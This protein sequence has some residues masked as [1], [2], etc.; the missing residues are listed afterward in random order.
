MKM[1]VV[2]TLKGPVLL[3][4]KG[5]SL[6]L[7]THVSCIAGTQGT[8]RTR[9]EGEAKAE[10][11][12]VSFLRLHCKEVAGTGQ[13]GQPKRPILSPWKGRV[14]VAIFKSW[15]KELRRTNINSCVRHVLRGLGGLD[16]R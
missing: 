6:G 1:V 11:T 4:G 8:V 14:P 13:P 12:E 5:N 7:I 16:R 2:S 3:K 9:K 15:E 10:L